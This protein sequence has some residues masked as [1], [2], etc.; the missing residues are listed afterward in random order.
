VIRERN[1][2][3][4]VFMTWVPSSSR[5]QLL[6]HAFNAQPYYINYFTKKTLCSTVSRYFVAAFHTLFALC[7]S[8]PRFVFVMN[9]PVFLPIIVYCYAKLTQS[10]YVLDSHSGLFNK[11]VWRT[12]I[13]IMKRI[14]KCASLNI[15]H[16]DH[17]AERYRAWGVKTAVLGT[18][19]YPYEGYEKGHLETKNNVV[20]IGSFST[21]EP[22]SEILAAAA[23][24]E[25]VHFY[26]TGSKKTAEKRIGTRG[27]TSNVTLTGFL[28]RNEFIGLVKAADV[29]LVLVTTGNTMQMGAWEAMS[30]GTP[31]ILS[32]W[33]LL[34]STFPKGAV[35]V[36]NTKESIQEG[37]AFF[38]ENQETLKKEIVQLK[39]EKQPLWDSEINRIKA[40]LKSYERPTVSAISEM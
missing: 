33:D 36:K 1:A 9:Q 20:V 26:F 39:M 24:L 23:E 15:A 22:T 4:R 17:D 8:R 40:I 25:N 32:D 18:E 35:F 7:R 27:I 13:P 3:D 16:N 12:F 10:H 11:R 38:F 30:C 31:L 2:S 29:A 34:R 19:I 21:D 6:S 5:T 28:P 37:I 14:Y